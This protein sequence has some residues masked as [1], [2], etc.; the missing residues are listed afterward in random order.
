M[1][2][3]VQEDSRRLKNV[4]EDLRR[5][6]TVQEFSKIAQEGQGCPY[7]FPHGEGTNVPMIHDN[8]VESDFL[9]IPS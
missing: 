2:K 8:S 3:K 1:F 7:I 6:N 9:F 4:Q 5:F